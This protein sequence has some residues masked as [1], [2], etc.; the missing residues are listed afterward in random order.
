[1]L[2]KYTGVTFFKGSCQYKCFIF[3]NSTLPLFKSRQY[4]APLRLTSLVWQ[5]VLYCPTCRASESVSVSARLSH[6][7]MLTSVQFSS[8]VW[9]WL[10]R[11]SCSWTL[12]PLQVSKPWRSS[13]RQ[14]QFVLEKLCKSDNVK[15]TVK[16][17]EKVPTKRQEDKSQMGFRE[18]F[19]ICT[20]VLPH[21]TITFNYPPFIWSHLGCV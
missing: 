11:L 16:E 2:K 13:V 7:A 17:K 18:N 20:L 21:P 4:C 5:A 19:R 10:R 1:M 14:A 8:S 15:K 3:L 9:Y 6:F 12:K